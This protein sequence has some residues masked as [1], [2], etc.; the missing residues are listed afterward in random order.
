MIMLLIKFVDGLR[1]FV[2]GALMI[3]NGFI[4][5]ELLTPF[6]YAINSNFIFKERQI[7]VLCWNILTIKL[8]SFILHFRNKKCF[9]K[10][11]K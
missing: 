1:I 10:N 3:A 9:M 5:S 4:C 2:L 6:M 11:Y 7:H 8:K